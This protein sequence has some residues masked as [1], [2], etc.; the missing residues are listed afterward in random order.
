MV[1]ASNN[2]DAPSITIFG[3][4]GIQGGSVLRH[5]LISDK[6]YRIR[7]VTRDSTKPAAQKLTEQG[8]EVVQADLGNQDEVEKA[9]KGQDLVFV[10]RRVITYPAIPPLLTF[11][12]LIAIASRQAVTNF[13]EHGREKE[14]ADGRRL[15]DVVKSAGIKK[16]FWSG[17]E[18]VSKVTNGK[19]TK[20]EHFDSKVRRPCSF[21]TQNPSR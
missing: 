12:V 13:W 11:I 8:V 3:A 19:Y 7:A 2:T 18:P 5:L 10:S 21:T 6:P 16:I 20:V 14:V 4:T 15:M 1:A 9:V 17:L